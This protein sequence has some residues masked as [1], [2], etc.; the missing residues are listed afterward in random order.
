M[1]QSE[2]APQQHYGNPF[3]EKPEKG[4]TGVWLN[5]D[6]KLFEMN[7]GNEAKHHASAI[8]YHC[9]AYPKTVG[10]AYRF[11]T[12][13][14]H[15]DNRNRALKAVDHDSGTVA[16]EK[17]LAILSYRKGADPRD[18][19]L[20]DED[21]EEATVIRVPQTESTRIEG[22][23]TGLVRKRYR[24]NPDLK[25]WRVMLIDNRDDSTKD[26]KAVPLRG[27]ILKGWPHPGWIMDRASDAV[28]KVKLEKDTTKRRSV[29]YSII[30]ERDDSNQGE[31]S[32]KRDV[33]DNINDEETNTTPESLVDRQTQYQRFLSAYQEVQSNATDILIP[34]LND[35]VEGSSSSFVF[36]AAWSVLQMTNPAT[37]VIGPFMYGGNNYDDWEDEMIARAPKTSSGGFDTTTQGRIDANL[38]VNKVLIDLYNEAWTN[39]LAAVNATGLLLDLANLGEYLSTDDT[40]IVP[41]SEFEVDNNING[42]NDKYFLPDRNGNYTA[43][44]IW[45]SNIHKHR[46][47][48]QSSKKH[49][50]LHTR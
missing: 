14:E 33:I 8:A 13:Q 22:P 35:M 23:M 15:N 4:A 31:E 3:A 32:R 26:F 38:A 39:G 12:T 49:S 21:R 24:E 2:Q 30:E 41:E 46:R 29:K 50:H 42:T 6:K 48:V 1:I 17:P 25:D 11:A 9:E 7:Y 40:A 45:S 36:D 28:K 34:I 19:N 43:A 16:D 10:K 5:H 37:F 27:P 20:F 47:S 18:T 44:P